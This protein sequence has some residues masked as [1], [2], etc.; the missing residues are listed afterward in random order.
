MTSQ[1]LI[2]T[3]ESRMSPRCRISGTSYNFEYYITIQN[4]EATTTRTHSCNSTCRNITRCVDSLS[5]LTHTRIRS[6]L[7]ERILGARRRNLL[8]SIITQYVLG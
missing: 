6:N 7:S 4:V 8:L 5:E 1:T 2:H 3:Q